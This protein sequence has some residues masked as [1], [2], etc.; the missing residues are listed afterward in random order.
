MGDTTRRRDL[1]IR[2]VIHN[3]VSYAG[4]RFPVLVEAEQKGLEGQVTNLEVWQG[5]QLLLAERLELKAGRQ[6]HPVRLELEAKGLGTRR[7]ELRLKPLADEFTLDNNRKSFFIDVLQARDKV[8]LLAAAPHPD[9]KAISTTLGKHEHYELHQHILSTHF[10]E[11]AL[12]KSLQ[13]ASLI[14]LHH[15]PSGSFQN[16]SWPLCFHPICLGS[17]L[18]GNPRCWATINRLLLRCRSR[19]LVAKVM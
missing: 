2:S 1:A 4:N 3:P 9:L 7:Y 12:K 15:V 13:Q 10:E 16:V 6:L 14:I 11:A 8:V 19:W 17:I 5:S 18:W